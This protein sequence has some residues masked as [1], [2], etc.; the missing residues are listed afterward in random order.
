MQLPIQSKTKTKK[1]KTKNWLTLK[2]MIMNVFVSVISDW[3]EKAFDYKGIE[4][5]VLQ[6]SYHKPQTNKKSILIYLEI[7][8]NKCI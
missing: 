6:K 8:M 4:F 5:P 3:E 2:I 1:K 7:K